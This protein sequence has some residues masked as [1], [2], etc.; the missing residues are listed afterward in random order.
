[1]KLINQWIL[2]LYSWLAFQYILKG[3]RMLRWQVAVPKEKD[4]TG[5]IIGTPDY[6]NQTLNALSKIN[7]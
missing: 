6:M 3:T 2:Q 4:V 1:M 5:L 7:E